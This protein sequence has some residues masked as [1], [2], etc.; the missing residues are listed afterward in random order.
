[1]PQMVQIHKYAFRL[2]ARFR[3][4]S[5]A[6]GFVAGHFQ[7]LK[8]HFLLTPLC[9]EDEPTLQSLMCRMGCR[10]DSISHC[11]DREEQ[12]QPAS[13]GVGRHQ[14]GMWH[15]RYGCGSGCFAALCHPCFEQQCPWPSQIRHMPCTAGPDLIPWNARTLLWLFLAGGS[16]TTLQKWISES[17]L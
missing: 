4:C 14:L 1:M 12:W 2:W 3:P 11:C 5:Q 13:P 10:W 6:P 8:S 9:G 7:P 15:P 17:S 16:G